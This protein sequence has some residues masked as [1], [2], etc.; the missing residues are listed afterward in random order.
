MALLMAVSLGACG[1]SRSPD[2]AA[3]GTT[4]DT[5]GSDS[6]DRR[7]ATPS[8]VTLTPEAVQSARIEVEPVTAEAGDLEHGGL[9]VPGQVE[10]DPHRVALASPRA[11]GR[12]ERLLAVEGDQVRLG[13]TVA[14]VASPEYL[15]AQSDFL[16]AAQ[17]ARLLA[18]SP[19]STGA[20]ALATAARRRLMRLGVGPDELDR[21]AAGGEPRE[22]LAITSPLDG[23]V[24]KARA[25][26]GAAVETGS[27]LFEVADL[28]VMDVIAQVPERSLPLLRMGQRA[29]VSVVAFPGLHVEGKVERLRGGLN[30]DTRTAE[31]VIHV[32]NPGRRLRPGM[33]AMVRLDLPRD[34]APSE[35]RGE[36]VLLIP[37]AAVVNDGENQIVFVEVGERT[38]ERREVRVEPH[39][40]GALGAQI[41]PQVR[42]REGLQPRERVVVRGAFILKSEL[43]KS[44]FGEEE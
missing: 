12:L 43:G 2:A 41:A 25:L 30:A 33:F 27:P 24:M 26:A 9:D 31:A 18:G 23:T 7:E 22:L 13:Q 8:R 40:A 37:S 36:P 3:A 35:A 16:Q 44:G 6:T 11:A 1:R 20:A 17:R 4:T 14:L 19:D 38:Y 5:A 39:A 28:A 15:T 10:F 29:S 21:L 32:A 34:A 42:V